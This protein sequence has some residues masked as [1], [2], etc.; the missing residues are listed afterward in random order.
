[1]LG[2]LLPVLTVSQFYTYVLDH[3]RQLFFVSFLP[4][5]GSYFYYVVYQSVLYPYVF[6][7]HL[8][9]KCLKVFFFQLATITKLQYSVA[10]N[11]KHL[12]I[13]ET[14]SCLGVN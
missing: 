3:L 8:I 11:N 13:P 2:N 4:G 1:M 6:L 7:S 5:F 12:L 14:L 9:M 10:Y